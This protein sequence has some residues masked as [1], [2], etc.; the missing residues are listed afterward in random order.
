MDEDIR[1]LKNEVTQI[2]Q[3]SPG[4]APANSDTPTIGNDYDIRID[5]NAINI[6]ILP[7]SVFDLSKGA[8]D[9]YNRLFSILSFDLKGHYQLYKKFKAIIKIIHGYPALSFPYK[10]GHYMRISSDL[11]TVLSWGC[12]GVPL[13][14]FN[15][16][17]NYSIETYDPYGSTIIDGQS[18]S[19]KTT[20]MLYIMRILLHLDP[21]N[22]GHAQSYVY[23][24]DPKFSRLGLFVK[25][26]NIQNAKAIVP[27]FTS[28]VGSDYLSRVNNVLK[29]LILKEKA[30]QKLVWQ[31]AAVANGVDWHS[32]R[33]T[34]TFC[35]I[36][37]AGLLSKMSSSR[38]MKVFRNRLDYLA[39]T[40]QGY[41]IFIYLASQKVDVT[42]AGISTLVTN[43]A[44]N[45]IHCGIVEGQCIVP[46]SNLVML[47]N[48]PY[49]GVMSLNGVVEPL[50][51]PTVTD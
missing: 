50:L 30:R 14:L 48:E 20:L 21:F 39:S 44:Q 5:D 9:L 34:P 13:Q 8:D 23:A 24:I 15:D 16:G 3:Y 29:H 35:L 51:L 4:I 25:Q 7:G 38:T 36:D 6:I 31:H 43:Q 41:G 28:G 18:R 19:G 47:P 37:E 40:A 17:N 2:I 26:H 45:L 42:N 32:F 10:Q 49:T 33:C 12:N 27:S 22:I 1:S 46:T 11:R